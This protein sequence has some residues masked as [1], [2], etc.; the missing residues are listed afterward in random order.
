VTCPAAT[1]TLEPGDALIFFTDG[2]TDRRRGDDFFGN[3]QLS[4]ETS[5]A[6]PS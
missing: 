4:S 5:T 1:V 6:R 2:V 3:S